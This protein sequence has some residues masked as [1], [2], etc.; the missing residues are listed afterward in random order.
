MF[1]KY[2]KVESA[3]VA[4]PSETQKIGAAVQQTGKS[5]VGEMTPDEKRTLPQGNVDAR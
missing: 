2:Q 1:R 4:T 3:T 5:S